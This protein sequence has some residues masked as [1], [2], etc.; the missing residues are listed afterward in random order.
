MRRWQLRE[1]TN[2]RNPDIDSLEYRDYLY[3]MD[4]MTTA[5][6]MA[7]LRAAGCGP[8]LWQ[9]G[10]RMQSSLVTIYLADGS[11]IWCESA[12]GTVKANKVW[13]AIHRTIT[14]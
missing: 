6:A 14:K 4:E 2:K 5:E 9:S 11:Q 1:S 3:L 8:R 7:E 13:A 10:Y 12:S